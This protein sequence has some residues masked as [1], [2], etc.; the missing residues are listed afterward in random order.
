MTPSNKPKTQ[1]E[2]DKI[3]ALVQ[4]F[5]RNSSMDYAEFIGKQN[6]QRE[7]EAVALNFS[8]AKSS[9]E[10]LEKKIKANTKKPGGSK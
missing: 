6:L 3:A 9:V 2:A 10:E 1:Q 5:W 4:R 8:N 7:D